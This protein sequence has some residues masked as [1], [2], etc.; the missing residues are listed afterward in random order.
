MS[1]ILT[2]L[3]S[4]MIETAPTLGS[5]ETTTRQKRQLARESLAFNV[6]DKTF[7]QLFPEYQERYDEEWKQRPQHE[8]DQQHQQQALLASRNNNND[9]NALELHSLMATAA[10][11]FAVVSIFFAL[12]MRF[13]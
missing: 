1:T 10:G 2:G 11:L 7:V 13:F 5:V 12:A 9:G 8:Q 6:R 4:F 3:Y